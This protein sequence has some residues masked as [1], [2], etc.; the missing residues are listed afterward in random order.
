MTNDQ[1]FDKFISLHH[2]EEKLR[3]ESLRRIA[4]KPDLRLHATII[5]QGQDLLHVLI[6]DEKHTDE[7]DLTIRLLGIRLFNATASTLKLL[8]SGYYQNATFQLRD[9]LETSFLLDYFLTDGALIGEWFMADKKIRTSKFA[10]VKVR[11]ALDDRDG[12][13]ERKR[14]AHYNMLC[15]LAA[16]PTAMGFQMLRPDGVDA[17]CGPFIEEKTMGA[18]LAELA[19]IHVHAVMI[20]TR[21]ITWKT[22][23]VAEKKIDFMDAQGRWFS[24]FLGQPSNAEVVAGLRHDL[25][26]VREAERAKAAKGQPNTSG[27]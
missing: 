25:A 7:D 10:P 22:S 5:E 17:H 21:F 1:P 16:H 14:E 3:A 2:G 8:L 27:S 19:K 24:H 9:L 18:V 4:A 26:A 15:E 23:A 20:F 11:V 6:H 13:T 12:F